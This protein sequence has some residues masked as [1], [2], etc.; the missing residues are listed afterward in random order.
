MFKRYSR[1]KYKAFEQYKSSFGREF[2]NE[3]VYLFLAALV[4]MF[5]LILG[6]VNVSVL[7]VIDPELLDTYPYYIMVYVL[8]EIHPYFVFIFTLVTFLLKQKKIRKDVWQEL[9]NLF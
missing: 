8:D 9:K 6:I 4:L 5:T 7:D 1:Q 3:D 2:T